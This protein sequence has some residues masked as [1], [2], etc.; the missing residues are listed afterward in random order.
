[1]GLEAL[2]GS[3]STKLDDVRERLIR[4]EEREKQRNTDL[5]LAA[6]R[7]AKGDEAFRAVEKQIASHESRIALL[8]ETGQTTSTRAW[9]IV[10]KI[11]I[12][13]FSA[14]LTWVIWWLTH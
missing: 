8:E 7:L 11:L 9:S 14:G 2:L 13:L 5:E 3:L 4:L 12:A 1:M 6:K 10:E